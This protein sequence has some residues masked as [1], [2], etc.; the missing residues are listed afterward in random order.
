MILQKAQGFKVEGLVVQCP[1]STQPGTEL[2]GAE[3]VISFFV[4][5]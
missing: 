1:I 4:E 5:A 2:T 3:L